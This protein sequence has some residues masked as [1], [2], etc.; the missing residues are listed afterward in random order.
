MENEYCA[1]SNVKQCL[2]DNDVVDAGLAGAVFLQHNLYVSWSIISIHNLDLAL[3]INNIQSIN[4]IQ[5][6]NDYCYKNLK[7]ENLYWSQAKSML[8]SK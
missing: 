4:I 5:N 7:I 8:G 6:E 2:V 1:M 3:Q